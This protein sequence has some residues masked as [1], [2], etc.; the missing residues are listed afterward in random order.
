MRFP[1]SS[2]LPSP[3]QPFPQTLASPSVRFQGEPPKP[4]AEGET[5]K[6]SAS[7][8]PAKKEGRFSKWLS[9][10]RDLGKVVQDGLGGLKKQWDALAEKPPT[11]ANPPAPTPVVKEPP[12]KEETPVVPAPVAKE[13]TQPLPEPTP[14]PQP[15]AKIQPERVPVIL[16]VETKEAPPEAILPT[17]SQPVPA[18][19]EPAPVKVS[20][21]ETPP[22]VLPPEIKQ[23]EVKLETKSEPL[24]PESTTV[25]TETPAEKQPLTGWK[26]WLA[27]KV[28][29]LTKPVEMVDNL[30]KRY[31]A[32]SA[33]KSSGLGPELKKHSAFIEA[34]VTQL[35]ENHPCKDSAFYRQVSEDSKSLMDV[36]SA[37]QDTAAVQTFVAEQLPQLI[38]KSTNLQ[39]WETSYRS[40]K[41]LM[42]ASQLS[43][44][45]TFFTQP[46]PLLHAVDT[47]LETQA[48]K[49]ELWKAM[50]SLANAAPRDEY[51]EGFLKQYGLLLNQLLGDS[52][53]VTKTASEARYK[54]LGQVFANQPAATL[55]PLVTD[56][57]ARF[58]LLMDLAAELPDG[59]WLKSHQDAVKAGKSETPRQLVARAIKDMSE[60]QAA[61]NAVD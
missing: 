12:V 22:V 44:E 52:A 23:P 45:S 29:I 20:V 51:F 31:S 61:K 60:K 49:P 48:K 32:R 18:Q 57:E 50:G 33:V 55:T 46:L 7:Q 27:R 11:P 16:P 25:L 37:Q 30:Q 40:I 17:P 8:P 28:P 15:E 41:G 24:D 14:V 36:L 2:P 26:G 1:S 9:K 58:L 42:D 5:P 34:N 10:G 6:P 38:Q 56:P 13:T 54:Q 3:L 59:D 4:P 53:P 43:P 39:D 47:A 19:P 35:L 21:P